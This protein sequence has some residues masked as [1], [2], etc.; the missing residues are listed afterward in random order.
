MGVDV[1]QVE[2]SPVM[3]LVPHGQLRLELGQELQDKVQI[4]LQQGSNQILLN[5][6]DVNMV[7]SSGLGTLVRSYTTVT[8]NGG[9][10]KLCGLNKHIKNLMSL[11]KLI[12]IF[13]THED[14]AAAIASFG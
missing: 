14:E 2:G 5:L 10:V 8:N 7:D 11:T 3:V 6:S 9:Q 4:L 13:S 12:L 1:R